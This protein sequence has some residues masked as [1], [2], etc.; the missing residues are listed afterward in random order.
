M[1]LPNPNDVERA[2]ELWLAGDD[3]SVIALCEANLSLYSALEEF[4]HPDDY[5]KLT[6]AL[7]EKGVEL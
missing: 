3:S 6:E 4:I 1:S 2:R 5:Q 7:Q